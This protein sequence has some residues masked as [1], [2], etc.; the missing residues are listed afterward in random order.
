LV[1]RRQDQGELFTTIPGSYIV[2]PPGCLCQDAGE[3]AQ[4]IIACLMPG[5]VIECLKVVEIKQQ[6][7]QGLIRPTHPPDSTLKR[8]IERAPIGNACQPDVGA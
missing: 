5:H 7:G 2:W 6:Q 8:L 3:L 4:H 1:S